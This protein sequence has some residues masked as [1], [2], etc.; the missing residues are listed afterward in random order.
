MAETTVNLGMLPQNRGEYS[1]SATYYKDNI[2]QY[3][4]SSYICTAAMDLEHPS[5]ITGVT[6]Y[7]SDPAT[8]NTGWAVFSNDSSG[9]GEGVYNVSV[10]HTTDN[11]P[12]VY[13]SLS[14]ALND[15]PAAK[16]KGGM[17]IKF[18]QGTVQNNDHKYVQFRLMHTLDNASTAAADF[19]NTANWQGVDDEPT[20]G[21]ENLVESGGT[22]AELTKK[23][24]ATY[25]AILNCNIDSGGVVRIV[26][27]YIAFV[28]GVK[29]SSVL[30]VKAGSTACIFSFLKSLP[31]KSGETADFCLNTS[32]NVVST[33]SVLNIP[34]DC[35]YIH[36]LLSL[37]TSIDYTP[38]VFEVD[39][40]SF[41]EEISNIKAYIDNRTKDINRLKTL[42]NILPYETIPNKMVDSNGD[43]VNSTD[44]YIRKYIVEGGSTYRFGA[45]HGSNNSN[46]INTFKSNDDY[47][48]HGFSGTDRI[49]DGQSVT[50]K[51]DVSYILM[52]V[53]PWFDDN[54]YLA[55]DDAGTLADVK[56][57]IWANRYTEP[58]GQGYA[59]LS[60]ALH[61]IPETN[62]HANA[63]V[64]FRDTTG[65]VKIYVYLSTNTNDTSWYNESYWVEIVYG[66]KI[67]KALSDI[68]N[69][70][71]YQHP[72]PLYFN[73][74]LGNVV[75]LSNNIALRSDGDSLEVDVTPGL[76]TN[77]NGGFGFCEGAVHTSKVA[78]GI[79]HFKINVRADDG[80]WVLG[81]T[82]VDKLRYKFKIEYVDSKIKFYIDGILISTYEGQKNLTISQLGYGS[83]TYG[84]WNGIIHSI[85]VNDSELSFSGAEFVGDFHLPEMPDMM[86]EKATNSI[87]VY[88]KYSD[89]LYIMYPLQHRTRT[90]TEN[91]YPSYFNVWGLRALE[92]HY[93]NGSTMTKLEELFRDGEAETAIRALSG[94]S[95]NVEYVSGSTHGFEN[96]KSTAV[97]GNSVRMVSILVDNVSVG[98][99]DTFSLKAIKELDLKYWSE[100]VQAYTNSNPFANA[101]KEWLFDDE[102]R[103]N[104]SITFTRDIAASNIMQG[105]FCVYRH[106]E[107]NTNYPYLTKRAVKDDT[108]YTVYNIE[109]GWE[110]NT[111][112]NPLKTQDNNCNK[113]TVYGDLGLGF[114][115]E[116]YDDNRD[117]TGGFTMATN[118]SVYNKIYYD[119]HGGTQETMLQ[120]KEYHATQ[121][122]EIL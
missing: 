99:T 28:I 69:I 63:I 115:M 61:A 16:Q 84:Y 122:W 81:D 31:L 76:T 113:I 47:I 116:V 114:S 56:P 44:W 66:Q 88:R 73:R 67:S 3:N 42:A 50:F 41:V 79:T 101:I 48:E 51:A 120:G 118:N 27:D 105:M 23:D 13:A 30:R 7:D 64:F 78:I 107:G 96:I 22:F 111:D 106:Q 11:Q 119:A 45:K 109:D 5:G 46:V 90:F 49:W 65:A 2:V 108:S 112:N 15:I 82:E 95:S 77:L 43:V 9:V 58:V 110:S 100:M 29:D 52:N 72:L 36:C 53:D 103:I 10:D 38:S 19:A 4:G 104:T 93:Y 33:S 68:A 83:A 85:K 57:I 98:E 60:A 59:N 75:K 86:C 18:I 117:N 91:Q 74:D 80:T 55:K 97:N 70:N 89:G 26:N 17:S 21:S 35:L 39:G 20:V 62:R 6:P 102:V 40:V 54:F 14:A 94:I 8:P 1:S 92:I 24:I 34:S 71:A 25:R 12:K 32:R 87:K 121:K 37:G